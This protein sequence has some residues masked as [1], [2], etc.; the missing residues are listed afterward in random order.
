[1]S[2]LR[3]PHPDK[4]C[5]RGHNPKKHHSPIVQTEVV[6]SHG[7]AVP[8]PSNTAMLSIRLSKSQTGLIWTGLNHIVC[9]YAM[10]E[11]K[12]EPPTAYPFRIQPLPR[13]FDTGT[14]SLS[15]MNRTIA[16]SAMLK[17]ERSSGGT[18]NMDSF[19]LRAAAFSSR[20]TLQIQRFLATTPKIR[21]SSLERRKR[22]GIDPESIKK[23][24]LKIRALIKYLERQ[25]KRAERRFV[26][27]RSSGEFKE[28]SKEWR[29]HLRWMQYHLAYFKPFR[30]V[31][32]GMRRMQRR[33]VDLLVAMAKK[34]IE[35][36]GPEI[37]NDKL[38]RGIIR[39]FIHDCRRGR[40][41]YRDFLYMLD[42]QQNPIAQAELLEYIAPRLGLEE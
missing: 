26:S 9:S 10:R 7:E 32:P 21:K 4:C 20:T 5:A 6:Y 39:S 29:A 16:L 19:Q 35:A 28:L 36:R 33:R 25:M 3:F 38:L 31:G 14:F 15:M 34:A 27:E 24:S 1:M 30:P 37:P 41:G 22:D 42:H 18:F 17:A 8:L 2:E 23:L 13:T 40:V 11:R 12:E